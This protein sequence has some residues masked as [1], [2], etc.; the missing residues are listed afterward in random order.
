MRL[1]LWLHALPRPLQDHS[2]PVEDERGSS[3]CVPDSEGDV[4][5]SEGSW[6]LRR[7]RAFN[8]LPHDQ[9]HHSADRGQRSVSAAPTMRFK[10]QI[11]TQQRSNRPLFIFV[12]TLISVTLCSGFPLTEWQWPNTHSITTVNQKQL[13]YLSELGSFLL[14]QNVYQVKPVKTPSGVWSPQ[15]QRHLV[16]SYSEK[17]QT[18]LSRWRNR[19]T[20][21]RKII[22]FCFWDELS[23]LLHTFE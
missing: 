5:R 6:E 17:R 8:R 12:I 3:S 7:R 1:K 22:C 16:P 18:N 19:T 10:S 13:N 2:G 15:A 4:C 20:G 21:E 23:L 14:W 11:T 9:H